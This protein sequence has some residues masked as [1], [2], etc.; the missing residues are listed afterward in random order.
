MYESES[1]DSVGM[2]AARGRRGAAFTSL[3]PV[4]T[5][6]GAGDVPTEPG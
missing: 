5:L 2:G 4:L 6:S 3:P 1:E